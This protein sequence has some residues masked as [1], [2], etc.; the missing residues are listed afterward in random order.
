MRKLKFINQAE[1]LGNIQKLIYQMKRKHSK[2]TDADDTLMM[3]VSPDFSGIVSTILSHGVSS[4]G[5]AMYSDVIHVPDPGEQPDFYR[6][7]LKQTWEHTI[8]RYEG[9]RYSKFILAE[10]GVISGRNYIWLVD[11][12]QELGVA[13][14]DI[15]TVAL[16]E[17]SHSKFKCDLVGEYYDNETEDLCFW[18]EQPNT[19]FGDFSSEESA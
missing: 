17:N 19:A 18:W 4:Y 9:G 11:T 13:R 7:R 16:Y 3:I 1:E 6:E 14:E 15:L 12:L 10:A 8:T 2:F 5:K